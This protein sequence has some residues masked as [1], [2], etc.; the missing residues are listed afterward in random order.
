ML[1]NEEMSAQSRRVRTARRESPERGRSPWLF[2]SQWLGMT[3]LGFAVGSPALWLVLASGDFGPL[4]WGVEGL[5]V[6]GAQAILLR[7]R[8]RGAFWWIVATAVGWAA[9]GLVHTAVPWSLVQGLHGIA[10]IFVASVL[11]GV[12]NSLLQWPILGMSRKWSW[13]WVLANVVAWPAGAAGMQAAQSLGRFI[14]VG[15]GFDLLAFL[16]TWDAWG[17]V[18]G[19]VQ[20]IVLAFVVFREARHEEPSPDG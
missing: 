20:G 12:A 13:C 6:G 9:G 18:V 7:R 3:T 14:N 19:A 16:A 5:F 10:R 2:W 1:G 11:T 15:R 4:F 17:V 8:V